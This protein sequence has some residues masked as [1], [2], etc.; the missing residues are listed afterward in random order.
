[1]KKFLSKYWKRIL[2]L[3]A[4]IFIVINIV[5]K[6]VAPHILIDEYA[7][8]G[9]DVESKGGIIDTSEVIASVENTSPFSDDMVKVLL[10]LA[11]GIIVVCIVSDL[12]NKKKAPAKK[13]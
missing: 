10:V 7:K 13:K 2:I 6:C 8:Y 1:M 3:I 12:I 4:A 5:S 9:P 11:G